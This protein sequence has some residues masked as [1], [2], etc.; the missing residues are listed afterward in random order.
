MA[1]AQLQYSVSPFCEK[2][3]VLCVQ[4]ET[5]VCLV[6]NPR[7]H[8]EKNRFSPDCDVNSSPACIDLSYGTRATDEN[9]FIACIERVICN[10][11]TNKNKLVITCSSGK[12]AKCLGSDDSPSCISDGEAAECKDGIAVCDFNNWQISKDEVSSFLLQ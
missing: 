11:D 8:E 10:F 1:C 6:S 12:I 2:N 3:K 9:I 7:I 5:P 4:N